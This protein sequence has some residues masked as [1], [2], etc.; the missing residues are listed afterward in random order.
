MC[1]LGNESNKFMERRNN[2]GMRTTA[3]NTTP[4]PL[5]STGKVEAYR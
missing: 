3:S 4:V 2:E 1:G 5:R